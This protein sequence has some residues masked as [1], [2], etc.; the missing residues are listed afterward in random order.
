MTAQCHDPEDASVHTQLREN[1]KLRYHFVVA[2]YLYGTG[3]PHA[4][5]LRRMVHSYA[6]KP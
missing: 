3:M 1:S 5:A 6:L 2:V 4:S